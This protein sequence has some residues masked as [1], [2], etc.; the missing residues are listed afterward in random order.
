MAPMGRLA[1]LASALLFAGSALGAD[2]NI[3]LYGAF[4]GVRT[5]P[6]FD[7]AANDAALLAAGAT[8][9]SSKLDRW[10]NGWKILVGWQPNRHLALEGGFAALGRASY[11]AAFT[12]GQANSEFKAGGIVFDALGILPL[13][14]SF[15]VFAKLGGI[16]A[17]VVTS[18]T[19]TP[20]GGVSSAGTSNARM[21]RPNFGAGAV[22]D[23]ASNL[24]VRFEVERFLHIGTDAT[25]VSNVDMI[26]LGLLL[27]L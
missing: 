25:G 26:S 20:P 3:Y 23:I 7:Q 13:G 14:D 9:F 12:A 22:L 11:D 5:D 21:F 6:G 10:D 17:S 16:A 27:K 15:S 24:S 4:G 8:E 19:V 18:Q 1:A 2:E